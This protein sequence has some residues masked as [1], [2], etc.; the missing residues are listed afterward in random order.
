MAF[1][2]GIK[3]RA[4]ELYLELHSVPKVHEKICREYRPVLGG[5]GLPSKNMEIDVIARTRSREI[6]DHIAKKERDEALLNKVRDKAAEELEQMEYTSAMEAT[7]AIDMAINSSR[8]ITDQT[9][10]LQFI[11]DVLDAITA[12]ITDE[13]MRHKLGIELRRIFQKYS[14]S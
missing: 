6:E 14:T 1:E 3:L 13:E 10:N 4:I 7:K 8:K 9:I 5:D 2:P 11:T 12:T